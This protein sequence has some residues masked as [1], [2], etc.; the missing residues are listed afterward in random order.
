MA[1]Y[2]VKELLAIKGLRQIVSNPEKSDA[3]KE[4]AKQIL[5]DRK[6]LNEYVLLKEKREEAIR[7]KKILEDRKKNLTGWKKWFI[8]FLPEVVI[9]RQGSKIGDQLF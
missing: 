2:T 5:N 6:L 3:V 7:R 4:V 1:K 8:R 9:L